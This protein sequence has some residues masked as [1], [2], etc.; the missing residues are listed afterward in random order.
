[1]TI[2]P[3]ER[4]SLR[5]DK[6]V[7]GIMLLQGVSDQNDNHK[8]TITGLSN[9]ALNKIHD[10][11]YLID[12]QLHIKYVNEKACQLTGYSRE[13]FSQLS[14]DIIDKELRDNDVFALWWKLST[15]PEGIQFTSHHTGRH[16]V[17]PVEVSCSGYH[18]DGELHI[19]C[20]VRDMHEIRR[21]KEQQQLREKQLHQVVENS[22]D[23]ILRFDLQTRCL[24]ANLAV[25]SWFTLSENDISRVPLTESVQR[26][27]IG[28]SLFKLVSRTMVDE[29]VAE[30]E[31]V[32]KHQGDKRTLHVRCVPE[33][34]LQGGLV[35]VLAVGRDIT[36]IRKTEEELRQ[37]THNLE[38]AREAEKKQLARDIH[39]ELG[40]HLTALRA[41]LSLLAMRKD[42]PVDA[43]QAKIQQ[44][45]V[46]LDSTIQVVR[47]VSTRLRP[48][49]LNLGLIP[50]LEWLRD[51]FIKNNGIRCILLAPDEHTVVLDEATLTAAFR[52]VQE[53]LT[54]V[55]RHARASNVYIFVKLTPDALLIE[56]VDNGKGFHLNRV[57]KGTCGLH[58]I[59][60]RGRMLNGEATID[61]TPGKGTRV[62]LKFPLSVSAKSVASCPKTG[63]IN[64]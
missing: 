58:G 53:S 57:K 40:Q 20:I 31:L 21:Q 2:M 43:Q 5:L 52:V 48:N 38:R 60:E 41:G 54:N 1:M 19:L 33:Y 29:K 45:M 42:Q 49:V 22:P 51:Q 32:V 7:E 17:F 46:H 14:F 24:Y 15:R 3:S 28:L 4:Y 56:V 61:S 55:V 25:R 44:L 35:S 62:K 64:R 26:G 63:S 37:L 18:Q 27:G 12:S 11:I 10:A 13:A 34:D 6:S 36:A 16:N 30:D 23:L 59:R 47:D 50:A 9:I 39:D 8:T